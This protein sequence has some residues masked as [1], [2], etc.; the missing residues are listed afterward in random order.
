MTA[1]EAAALYRN[2]QALPPLPTHKKEMW[3]NFIDYLD[4]TGNKGNALLDDRNENMGMQLMN[5][6]KRQHPDFSLNY[7]DVK[8]VQQDLQ[9]YRGAL[10]NNWK[11]GTAKVNNVNNESDIMPGLSPVD[12]WLGKQTSSHKYPIATFTNSDKT[13]KNYGTD[14]G[15]YDAAIALAKNKK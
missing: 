7:D 9:D 15:A 8:Q 4:K 14:T 6:Y 13:V 2:T 3:N 10:V 12:G 1:Q 11:N 5:A